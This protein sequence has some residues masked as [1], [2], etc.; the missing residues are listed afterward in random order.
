MIH[1]LVVSES[2]GS[3]TVVAAL[4]NN[5]QREPDEL[6]AV[7]GAGDDSGLTV[8]LGDADSSI[9]PG[10]AVQLGET[11]H[12]TVSG[13][14]VVAGDF[15]RL[16]FT[17]ANGE[18]AELNLPVVAAT[19][20]YAGLDTSGAGATATPTPAGTDEPTGQPTDEPTDQP[21]EESGE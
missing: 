8:E 4:V 1:A 21:S 16:A 19:D 18:A 11:G 10:G 15:V 6:T 12:V 14:A 9:P 7:R 13:D 2:D 5:D 20:E 3:G 17:F